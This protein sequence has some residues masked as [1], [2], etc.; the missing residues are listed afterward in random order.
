MSVANFS[1]QQKRD[2]A[3]MDPMQ[4]VARVGLVV[5]FD[6]QSFTAQVTFQPNGV[7]SGWL[8]VLSQWVGAGWGMVPWLQQND[9]VLVVMESGESGHGVIVGRYFNAV[10]PPPQVGAAG[11]FWLVHQSGS[12]LALRNDGT[13]DAVTPTFKITGDLL[14][15]GNISDLN[16][17]HSTL[18][19]LRTAYDGHEHIDPQGGVTGG[20]SVTV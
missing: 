17:A 15:T 13:I 3:S 2:A 4:G 12:S 8:P 19:A 6:P 9:Q 20:P 10:D 1:A 16:G 11:E 5:N 7:Q 14:V 18:A